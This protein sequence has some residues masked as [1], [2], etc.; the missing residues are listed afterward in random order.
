MNPARV[1]HKDEG[2]ESMRHKRDENP[3]TSPRKIT[4]QRMTAISLVAIAILF[5]LFFHLLPLTVPR[6]QPTGDLKEFLDTYFSTWSAKDMAGYKAHFHASAQIIYMADG[7]ALSV[8]GREPFI[9]QQ[10]LSHQTSSTP[11]TER[12]TS[13]EVLEDGKAAS[14]SAKWELKKGDKLITGVDRYTVIRDLAGQWKIVS[15]VFYEDKA[16]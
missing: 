11:M 12:M 13:C 16:E 15:L 5:A 1:Q 9:E 6:N 14:V 2:T 3:T 7:R 4:P 10:T 8:L